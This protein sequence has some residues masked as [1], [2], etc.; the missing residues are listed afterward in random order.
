MTERVEILLTIRSLFL[1][2]GNE[3]TLKERNFAA[4][5]E[6]QGKCIS[7]MYEKNNKFMVSTR[8]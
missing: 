5:T 2:R 3:R 7:H 8:K 6:K 4:K 1:K